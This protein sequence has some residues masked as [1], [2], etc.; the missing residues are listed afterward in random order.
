MKNILIAS[1][2]L[3]VGGVE[4]SLINMLSNF[5]YKKYN[6][7]LMLYSHTGEFMQL[8][9]PFPSL[10]EESSIY[11]T[12][13]MSIKDTIKSGEWMIGIARLL[14]KFRT[15]IFSSG[16]NSYT[17]MQ[18]MWK[19]S[20]PFLPKSEKEYDVAISY[21]WPHYYVAEQIKATK[22]I[23]WVHTDF[24]IIQTDVR[25]DLKMW[26]KFDYIA[27]VSE[28]CGKAFIS[29]YPTLEKKVIIQENII[30][31]DIVRNLANEQ[32]ENP[33]VFDKR[34]KLL[35]VARLS[36][37]KGIDQAIEAFKE[38]RMKGYENIAWYVVGYGGEENMLRSLIAKYGLEDSFILLGKKNNPYPFIQACDLYVQPSRYEG[39]AVT[40]T[41][42]KMLGKPIVITNYPTAKSQL[43][44]GVDG[45]I[46]PLGV[47]GLVEGIKTLMDNTELR[48]ELTNKVKLTNYSNET[49]LE[50]IYSLVN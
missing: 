38:L 20:I 29:K 15:N 44:S 35:T 27:A 47:K 25:M 3:E 5:D 26:N 1:F 39:K 7:D 33:M 45:Y 36:H 30:T 50:K 37:A 34:F 2:D 10:I 12:F 23:A 24:S 14:A 16:E 21:L 18:Y 48:M 32:L 42:A 40:V 9:P 6:V 31:S 41:E 13:R 22:K 49:E 19:Y 8:L 46:C 4:R 11:K 17:Q 28:E 43:E